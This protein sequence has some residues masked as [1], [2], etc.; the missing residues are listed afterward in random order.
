MIDFW[1]NMLILSNSCF[2]KKISVCFAGGIT[3][4][5][6]SAIM[7]KV[8]PRCPPDTICHYLFI[9]VFLFGTDCETTL[10]N[11]SFGSG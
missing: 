7:D 11:H 8:P 4:E 5:K 6:M 3:H 2:I 10:P 1:G 9:L